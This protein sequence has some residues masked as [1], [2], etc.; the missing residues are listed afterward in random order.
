MTAKEPE[1][2]KCPTCGAPVV[3]IKAGMF[4]CLYTC[5][6]GHEWR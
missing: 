2:P 5:E 6:N 4:A 1:P 3:H